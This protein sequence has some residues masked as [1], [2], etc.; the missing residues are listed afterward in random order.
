MNREVRNVS[1]TLIH[2]GSEFKLDFS[3]LRE[4][5]LSGQADL[6]FVLALAA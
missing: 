1:T 3:A 4:K 5:L 6:P 2:P